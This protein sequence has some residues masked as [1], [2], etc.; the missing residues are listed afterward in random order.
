MAN[1]TSGR[2]EN[3][4]KKGKAFIAFLTA[5]DPDFETTEELVLEMERVRTLG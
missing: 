2:I 4:F 3:A 1:N 5:G